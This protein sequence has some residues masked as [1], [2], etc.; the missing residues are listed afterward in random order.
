MS[1]AKVERWIGS[2]WGRRVL[3]GFVLAIFVTA[4]A[5]GGDDEG[6]GAGGGSD[7]VAALTEEQ[8]G[9]E[10]EGQGGGDSLQSRGG[11]A[12]YDVGGS[13]VPSLGESVVKTADLRIEV[14]RD[15]LRA[16]VQRIEQAAPR[17]GGF[18]HST[19]VDDTRGSEGI[20]VL[21]IPADDFEVALRDIKQ[22]GDV[23]GE[24][25]SGKDVSQE[26]IDLNA[27]IRNLEAQE[28]VLLE[29]MDKATTISE[30][31]NVQ[32]NLSGIQLEIERLRGRL[33]YLEDR[34]ALS[35]ISVAIVEDGA[36]EPVTASTWSRAWTQAGDILEGLGAGSIIVIVGFVL[37]F[38]AVFLL[39]YLIFRAVRPRFTST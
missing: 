30:T 34:T 25:V 16:A 6:E 7:E 3:V 37:P 29:L 26:F 22:V 14:E 39:G 38:G 33:N 23:L 17:Y 9:G 24:N 15:G 13:G 5:C 35:T 2:G 12:A 10:F 18:V 20:V 31:I 1:Q 8:A 21:R 27:R 28:A 19:S 4:S 11:S 32:N 36:P